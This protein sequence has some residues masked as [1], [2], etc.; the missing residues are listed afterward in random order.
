MTILKI[1]RPR[2]TIQNLRVYSLVYLATNYSKFPGGIQK[3]FE[4][5]SKLAARLIVNHIKIFSPIAHTHPIA[6]YGEVN[7]YDHSIWL[8]LDESMMRAS[9]ALLVAEFEGWK[10]SYGVDQEIKIFT[11]DGKPIHYINPNSLAIR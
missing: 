3:A 1:E 5:A 7:P 6:M 8:E 4:E 9:Q 10:E 2:M 11:R